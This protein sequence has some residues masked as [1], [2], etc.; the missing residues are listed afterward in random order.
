MKAVRILYPFLIGSVLS[1][2]LQAQ[3]PQLI[4]YQGRVT[5]GGQPFSGNG[6]FKFALVGNGGIPVFWRNDGFNLPGEPTVS[7]V[8]PATNGLFTVVLGNNTLPGMAPILAGVFSSSEVYLRIWFSDGTNAFAQLSPDQRI[9]AVG[10]AL[11][12]ETVRDGAITIDKIAPG[13][14]DSSKLA[15]GAAASNL[16]ASGRSAVASG[17]VILSA[18]EQ[19]TNLFNEGYVRIGETT[20][21]NERWRSLTNGPPL[22]AKALKRRNP[23]VAWTGTEF[24]VWGGDDD[25]GFLNTGARYNP[26]TDTW[27][28]MNTNGAPSSQYASAV[29]TGTNFVVWSGVGSIPGGRYNPVTDTWLP[30]STNS[31]PAPRLDHTTVWTGTYMIIWGGTDTSLGHVNTGARYNPATDTW[32]TVNTIG[33]PALRRSHSGVWTGSE[34]I[35]WGGI[36]SY[37]CGLFCYFATNYVD[38]ARYNPSN[39]TWATMTTANAPL[40]RYSHSAVWTGNEMIVWGGLH[41]EG[42]F[43]TVGTNINTGARYN[44]SNNTW[45]AITSASAPTPRIKHLAFWTG[46]R[47]LIWGGTEMY[48]TNFNDGARY[49]PSNNTWSA[50]SST[51]APPARRDYSGGWTG[52]EMIVCG[53][54]EVHEPGTFDDQYVELGRRYNAT[55]DSWAIMPPAG[56]PPDRADHTAVWTGTEMLV[57]GG[58]GGEYVLRTGGRLDPSKP[59]SNCWSS[60]SITGA[61]SARVYHSAVWTGSEMIIWGGYNGFSNLNTGA[62]YNPASNTWNTVSTNNAPV[63][64]SQH[65]AVWT[66]TEML[67]WGGG[68][69]LSF[70]NSGGRYNPVTDTWQTLPVLNAPAG[71]SDASAVWTGT[72]IIVW[73][74]FHITN[75]IPPTVVLHNSGG[76]FNPVS[77]IWL[78]VSMTNAPAARTGHTAVWSGSDMLIWGGVVGLDSGARY[79][80]QL[81][82]W[83]SLPT[84]GAPLSRNGHKAVWDGT[85]MIVWGGYDGTNYLTGGVYDPVPNSWSSVVSTN[86]ALPRDRHTAVWSGTEMIF[87]GGHRIVAS[88]DD[89]LDD[90]SAYTPSRK[91]FLYLKP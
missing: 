17:G 85:H 28:H 2:A 15:P 82:Q 75:G 33:A 22:T 24:I 71:R 27:T 47:M 12:A 6:Q 91:M 45:I 31:A 20:L 84:A 50:I 73:G 51:N 67:V 8:V 44:P 39:N 66:G 14:I 11:M 26:A 79:N 64:R 70:Y 4:T 48:G 23:A 56:D 46:N 57:W 68:N 3:V 18:L 36:Y 78:S 76:R 30:V 13:A 58:T 16:L 72:E 43:G 52:T 90:A 61:P 37:S 77:N 40:K 59:L 38:G 81:N 53:G 5:S 1:L 74:G 29:W 41:G 19:A 86:I 55:S 87:W 88:A 89:Y 10:Y 35:I 32:S 60:I 42:G 25:S 9:T 7:V 80:P 65:V 49:N 69:G 83:T 54:M 21:V 63:A 62:R 34:M